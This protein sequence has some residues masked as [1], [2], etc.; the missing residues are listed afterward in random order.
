[1]E[2]LAD[3][4]AVKLAE[5][6]PQAAEDRWLTSAEAAAYLGLPYSTFRKLTAAGRIEGEQDTIGGRFYFQRSYLDAWRR[7][8]AE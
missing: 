3:A 5:S 6:V 4:V 7:R 2:R 8:P 1:L